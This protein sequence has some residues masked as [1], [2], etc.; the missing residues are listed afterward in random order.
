MSGGIG[1]D[2]LTSE[3]RKK[4]NRPQLISLGSEA[5]AIATSL[6]AGR[7][8]RAEAIRRLSEQRG[9]S[10]TSEAGDLDPKE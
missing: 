4:W 10:P 7:P 1:R 3:S 5:E 8:D 6:A 9:M 2:F